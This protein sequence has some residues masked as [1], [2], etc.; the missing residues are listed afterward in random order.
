MANGFTD[1]QRREICGRA[2]TLYERLDGPANCLGD[3]PPL[4]PEIVLEAFRDNYP[5]EETFRR[6]LRR[7]GLTESTI[8]E[9]VKATRWPA[10]EPLPDWINTLEAVL[11]HVE[12]SE[13]DDHIIDIAHP[14][15]PFT[16]LLTAIAGHAWGRLPDG[17]VPPEAALS[18]VD[19]FVDRLEQLCVRV[20]YVEFKSFVEY[21]EPD[22][23]TDDLETVSDAPT[24][25][26]ERFIDAMFKH[27]FRNLCIEYPVLARQIVT[28][29]DQWNEAVGELCRRIHSDRDV[30]QDRFN[31]EG[32][33]TALEPLADDTHAG[34]RIPIRV[35][36]ESGEVIYKPR[37]VDGGV[38]FYTV[39]DRLEEH[40]SVPP[41]R[42]PSYL[43]QDGYGWMEPIEFI[44]LPDESAI[45]RYYERAGVLLCLLYVLNFTDCTFEN[46][47]ANGEYPVV[48]DGETVLHP[49]I[50]P[51]ARPGTI[52]LSTF[53]ERSIL[54]TSLLPFHVEF[55]DRDGGDE[56]IGEFIAG[57]GSKSG[58]AEISD[59][60]YP[61]ID[62]VNTDLMRI[63]TEPATIT[64]DT[65]I[66]QYRDRDQPPEEYVD[67]IV[68]GFENTYK[69]ID[70]LHADGRFL[71]EM[72]EPAVADGFKNRLLY[73]HTT[74]YTLVLARAAGRDP[75]RDAVRL[76]AAFESLAV[77]FFDG[78]VE[79]DRYWPMY[80]AERRALRRRDVPRIEARL[81]DGELLHDGTEIGMTCDESG[82]Q[83]VRRR[84]GSLSTHDRKRQTWLIRTIF[85][86]DTREPLP[87]ESVELT[88]ERLETV[89]ISLFDDVIDA[90]IETVDGKRWIQ[91]APSST[92]NLIPENYS[93]YHG[94]NGIALTAAA[95]Y[96]ATG[97][98]RYRRLADELLAPVVETIATADLS[99]GLGGM[100]G[101]GS[102]VYTLTVSAELVGRDL[103]RKRALGAI[104]MITEDWL[105]D[106]ETHDVMAGTAGT[107]LALLAYHD[108][109]GST[110]AYKRAITCGERLLEARTTR[111]G[112]RV[113]ETTDD[114]SV[115]DGFAHGTTGIAYALARLGA[116]TDDPRY[117]EAAREALA[118]ESASHSSNTAVLPSSFEE[119]GLWCRGRSGKALGHLA[120][121]RHLDDQ[122]AVDE[123]AAILSA[124][125]TSPRPV[126]DTLCCGGIGHVEAL[127]VWARR[128]DG[129][130]RDAV[131]MA[132][133][134][135]ARREREGSFTLLGHSESFT[136]PT[137]FD[138]ASGVA[139]T[140][141]RL[142]DPGSLP[143][144]PLLE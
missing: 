16:E 121:G 14:E 90:A 18:M 61:A 23:F 138:G 89:A 101:I 76:S 9:Q 54:L 130:L 72:L 123:A 21:H 40:L 135:L 126:S 79:S 49:H 111:D 32:E 6:R 96:N 118:Y 2:R 97:N 60:T 59:W 104:Q 98:R 140:L 1:R 115:V 7:E 125:G 63:K 141:L 33:P 74:Q 117:A 35:S 19:S 42:K 134:C 110:S 11:D 44:E 47:I 116:T 45:E 105:V 56:H 119:S 136:N 5:D 99:V 29:L 69:T 82:Y 26:Y 4:D 8:R 34:G 100:R 108:R 68:R 77:P 131:E 31:I 55:P 88:D 62:A 15:T 66:P 83:R 107:L 132:G 43:P 128:G 70:E 133:R 129:D 102:V 127:V 53:V 80:R 12:T 78:S 58:T 64:G 3:E 38:V 85:G 75:L 22:A 41:F 67:A 10:D 24:E 28:L 84:L 91:A 137:F 51:D 139:Y 20:L 144:V 106:D 143:C 93:L 112:Y 17:K 25:Y 37:D 95:L 114:G 46:L 50:R 103:Y 124:G 65:N 73:R 36:F 81:R 87:T 13:P 48:V 122:I 39:L 57:L 142:R 71:S 94:R 27:G 120:V 92:I 52:G 86:S 109:Y 113:W 30:L